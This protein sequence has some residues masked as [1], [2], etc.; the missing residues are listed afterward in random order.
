MNSLI[1][2]AGVGVGMVVFL[3]AFYWMAN[4]LDLLP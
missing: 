2:A 4:K 3:A 1:E